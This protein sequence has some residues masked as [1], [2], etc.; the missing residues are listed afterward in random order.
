M[1]PN[2]HLSAPVHH[3]YSSVLMQSAHPQNQ[4]ESWQWIAG[5]QANP[6]LKM[7]PAWPS[8]LLCSFLQLR[9]AGHVRLLSH[10]AHRLRLFVCPVES[11]KPQQPLFLLTYILE[12]LVSKYKVRHI[13]YYSRSGH[14]LL[15]FPMRGY[16]LQQPQFHSLS[17]ISSAHTDP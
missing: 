16:L 1:T 9:L 11:L 13:S 12:I 2:R 17:P 8:L 6:Y 3:L 14:H 10:S 7:P 5:H 4:A 15:P